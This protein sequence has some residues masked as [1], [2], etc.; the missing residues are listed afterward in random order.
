MKYR[1]I[2]AFMKLNRL[3]LYKPLRHYDKM[4]IKEFISKGKK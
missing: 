2:Y 1:A 3:N 4:F